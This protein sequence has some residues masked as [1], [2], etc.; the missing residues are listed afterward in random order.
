MN[1]KEALK[2]YQKALAISKHSVY[3][4]DEVFYSLVFATRRWKSMS[5]DVL[6]NIAD[7]AS[8][9]AS[10]INISYDTALVRLGYEFVHAKEK[11]RG[12]KS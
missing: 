2:L 9:Y 6:L 7:N 4:F 1:S 11:A 3:S 12:N 5:M 10:L 8:Q